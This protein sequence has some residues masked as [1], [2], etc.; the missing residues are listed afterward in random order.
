[1]KKDTGDRGIIW[2]ALIIIPACNTLTYATCRNTLDARFQ[3]GTP[4]RR[5]RS[6]AFA[7]YEFLYILGS[8]IVK[9]CDGLIPSRSKP[10][11]VEFWI[12]WPALIK[13]DHN[14]RPCLCYRRGE[15][16]MERGGNMERSIS[17]NLK[18]ISGV[19]LWQF[20]MLPRILR[21]PRVVLNYLN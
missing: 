3:A 9:G 5:T 11:P 12:T 16:N 18:T 17:Q 1:M 2:L 13:I 6:T 14:I 21:S 7:A 8:P 20:Y 15:V 4:L 10:E 19:S